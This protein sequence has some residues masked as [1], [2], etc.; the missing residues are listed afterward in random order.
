MTTT[1][2]REPATARPTGPEAASTSATR[3]ERADRLIDEA[4]A[5]SFPAS[6]PPSWWAGG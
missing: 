3:R 5:A 2:Q 4:A 1:M 6:D